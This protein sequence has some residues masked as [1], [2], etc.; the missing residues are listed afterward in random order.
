VYR[1]TYI[2]AMQVVVSVAWAR[3]SGSGRV[4]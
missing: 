4:S 1:S 2:N 3:D